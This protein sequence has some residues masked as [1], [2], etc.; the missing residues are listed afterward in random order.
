MV[1]VQVLGW[2]VATI[3]SINRR[4]GGFLVLF[5]ARTR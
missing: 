2:G 5:A 3:I 1:V 4:F